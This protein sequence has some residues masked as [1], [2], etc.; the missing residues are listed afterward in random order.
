MEGICH[1]EVLHLLKGE[2]KERRRECIC[3]NRVSYLLPKDKSRR[4]L[5]DL[6]QGVVEWKVLCLKGGFISVTRRG[7]W[8][9][10]V[11]RAFHICYMKRNK[12]GVGFLS[13]LLQGKGE[14]RCLT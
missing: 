11:T 10:F 9:V 7:V 13:H 12:H 14:G 8:K 6:L 5:P 4:F 1:K 3:H 2:E